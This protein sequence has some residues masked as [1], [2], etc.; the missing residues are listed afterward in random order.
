MGPLAD[1]V[2]RNRR[3]EAEVEVAGGEPPDDPN[4]SDRSRAALRPVI[5]ATVVAVVVN[6]V[7]FV[8]AFRFA[9]ARRLSTR[10]VILGAVVAAVIWQ[11]LQLFGT[12]YVAYGV[13]P[14]SSAY[15]VFALVFGLFAWIF[16]GAAGLVLCV[17]LNVVRIKRLYPR[18]L[19]TPF[20]DNV[21]LTDADKQAYA[22]T[23]AAQRLKEFQH[24]DVHFN[25]DGQHLSA[26]RR[27][28]DPPAAIDARVP[29]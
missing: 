15:G 4:P 6:A 18:A 21:D 11:L 28:N 19:L 5:L 2:S 23:A 3:Q 16:L 7:V 17:E 10:D 1:V 9:T 25:D 13:K 29:P 27:A 8:I 14:S 26:T 20:T 24:I 22:D 12:A